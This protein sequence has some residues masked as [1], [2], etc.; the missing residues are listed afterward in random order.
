MTKAEAIERAWA[1]LE[2]LEALPDCVDRK[3]VV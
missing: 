3:S 2:V 1:L